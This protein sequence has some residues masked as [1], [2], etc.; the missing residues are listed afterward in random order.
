MLV[1]IKWASGA[2]MEV[3]ADWYTPVRTTPLAADARRGVL[4][5]PLSALCVRGRR[6]AADPRPSVDTANTALRDVACA[7]GVLMLTE[8]YRCWGD[9][10]VR[11]SATIDVRAACFP[12]AHAPGGGGH[13]ITV[14]PL[15]LLPLVLLRFGRAWAAACTPAEFVSFVC[16]LPAAMHAEQMYA[17]LAAFVLAVASIL[18]PAPEDPRHEVFVEHLNAAALASIVSDA[19]IAHTWDVRVM[20]TSRDAALPLLDALPDIPG[21]PLSVRVYDQFLEQ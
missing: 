19:I 15:P 13:A 16:A 17:R 12:V 9:D 2:A 8:A 3:T 20:C 5:V 11:H 21:R 14:V 18:Q 1:P 7:H 4:A 10:F 6:A